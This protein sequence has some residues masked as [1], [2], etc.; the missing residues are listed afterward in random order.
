MFL[1]ILAHDHKNRV[2]QFEFSR[3]GKTISRY[4]NAVLRGV[5][6]LQSH[7]LKSP[8]RIQGLSNGERWRHFQVIVISKKCL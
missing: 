1:N 5:L 2:I 3:S 4:F 6:K 7:L 8:Q